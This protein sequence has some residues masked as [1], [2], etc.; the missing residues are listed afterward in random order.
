MIGTGTNRKSMAYVDNVAAFLQFC[1]KQTKPLAIINYVDKP[2][3]TMNALVEKVRGLLGRPPNVRLRLPKM[4]GL[5][6][7]FGF[8]AVAAITRRRLAISSI[9]VRKFCADSV[10]GSALGST[11][12]VPPVT[13]DD[14][15]S[16]TVRF[17][18][19]DR[20]AHDLVFETE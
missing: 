13:L 4:V 9:R 2:D 11:G 16:R 19:I 14:A 15:L 7:G 12:F 10:Y 1:T 3:F 18:F 6:A 20:P 5:L 17:E 8:D